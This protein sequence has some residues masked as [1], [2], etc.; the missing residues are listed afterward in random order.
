MDKLNNYFKGDLIAASSWKN[1]YC[2][3]D[4]QGNALEETPDDMHKRLAKSFYEIEKKYPWDLNKKFLLSD[5]GSKQNKE[6]LSEQEIYE[7]FKNFKYIIPGGSLMYGLNNPRPVSLSNCFVVESPKDNISEIFETCKTL[8]NIY[9]KR[10]GVGFDISNL[11][12]KGA[13]VNNSALFSTGAC[14]FMD[15]FS[16]TTNQIAE[17][18]RRG[19]CMI[20]L[21][22]NHPDVIDFA[23]KKQDLTKVT[24]ANVSIQITDIFLKAVE[25]NEDFYLR[26]PIDFDINN[27]ENSKLNSLEYNVLY[28][29]NEEFGDNI[30]IKKVKAK[31]VWDKIVHCAWNTAEP[32]LIFRDRMREYSPDALYPN[33]KMVCTN[34]C[35]EVPLSP[36]DSCRLI[37]L[38]LKS[39]VENPFTEKSK[40]D[41]KKLYEVAYKILILGDDIVDLELNAVKKIIN[42]SEKDKDLSEQNLWDKIYK[43]GK[44]TRRCGCG[45]T[46]L[47]DMIAMLNLKYDSDESLN[48][49]DK[50]MSII[51]EAQLDATID[52]AI[53]RGNFEGYNNKLENENWKNNSWYLFVK[54]NYPKQFE[55]MLK[56]GRRN[57]S[58]S[59]IAPTGTVSLMAQCSSGIEPVFAPYYIRKVKCNLNTDRVDVIDKEGVKYTQYFIIHP[60][61][62]EYINIKY[63]HLNIDDLNEEKL[64][65]IIENSPWDKSCSHDINWKQR[66]K[67][68]SICQKYITHSISSTINLPNNITKQEVSDIYL[69]AWKC[70]NKGQTIYR[71]GCRDGVLNSIKKE[72]PQEIILSK[73]PKR[74][75]EL[76]ADYYEIKSKGIRYAILVGLYNNKP[77]EIF[78][79]ELNDNEQSLKQH[80]G[81]IIKI[82]KMHYRFVSDSITIKNLQLK[83]EN[84]EEKAATLYSSMLLRHGVDI[85][86]IIKTAKKVNEN[87]VSFSS[88]IC[89]I[90]SK[91]LNDEE[92]NEKCPECGGRLVREAGCIH[93]LDCT[94]SKCM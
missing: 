8:G 14:S 32:G 79:F 67:I 63:P 21:N 10:G 35:G 6:I 69:E 72:K 70:G 19:A 44:L 91:Y 80:R 58:F 56:Y 66:V 87:I 59:T 20:S 22:V 24:G 50:A 49:I 45:L 61:L 84:V 23:E 15:I 17:F 1:K 52:L 26:F 27:I 29:I 39:F 38:N 41:Y 3:T 57:I 73:A 92:L 7:L 28:G 53:Q 89:R 71:D 16:V 33:F 13:V 47:S 64:K 76:E 90:L 51:F 5:F 82:G 62:K 12:P 2:L 68:Q 65:E 48:I 31:E 9:K 42:K 94:Y 85:K 18:G 75:N 93:C 54:N 34:P 11:R 40:I 36:Y 43:A 4:K 46:G 30:Y 88:A 83:N 74:P 55:R 86:Y 25:N 60:T 81:K 77:Y 78:A 37:H